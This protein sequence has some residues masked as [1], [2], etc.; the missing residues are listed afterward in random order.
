MA[1]VSSFIATTSSNYYGVDKT[2]EVR[3]MATLFIVFLVALTASS[4]MIGETYSDDLLRYYSAY[5]DADYYGLFDYLEL[6]Q[7]EVVFQAFNWFL[8]QLIGDVGI[9]GFLF[10]FSF[11]INLLVGGAIY[12]V[13]PE[14][15][16]VVCVLLCLLTPSYLLVSTQL[17]R[18]TLA[19]ALL[20]NFITT[21]SKG[22]YAYLVF[23]VS[24]HYVVFLLLVPYILIK[25]YKSLLFKYR[26]CYAISIVIFLFLLSSFVGNNYY[27]VV[28]YFSEIP[29]IGSK[30]LYLASASNE[31]IEIG[32]V[33]ISSIFLFFVML[34]FK[35][36]AVLNQ[37][38]PLS[39]FIVFYFVLV[40]IVFLFFDFKSLSERFFGYTTTFFPLF[41][42]IILDRAKVDYK[43]I[44]NYLFL[45]LYMSLFYMAASYKNPFSLYGG[46]LSGG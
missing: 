41:F 30:A 5:L 1:V 21:K 42:Y 18:Q 16:K 29:V 2:R 15:Y 38:E 39:Q 6:N 31:K 19:I 45:F 3:V 44:F 32:L 11:V 4:R 34:F 7:R 46:Y 9:R 40:L 36:E 43:L 33:F 35:G 13:A 12:K 37:E 17:I 24:M 8:F 20:L 22:K 14:R 28:G 23:S 10:V 27:Q 26:S 25:K